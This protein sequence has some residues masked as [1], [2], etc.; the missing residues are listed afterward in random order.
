M[1]DKTVGEWESVSNAGEWETSPSETK[2]RRGTIKGSIRRMQEPGF[3][4]PASQPIPTGKELAKGY[5]DVAKATGA[6]IG[7]MGTGLGELVPGP[8]GEASAKGSKYL[9]GVITEAEKTPGVSPLSTALSL[10]APFGLGG[11]FISAAKTL[12][13]MAG[14]TSA[15]GAGYGAATPTGEEDYGERVIGKA[16]PTAL[17]VVTGALPLGVY[18]SKAASD[19]IRKASGKTYQ[20]AISDLKDIVTKEAKEAS[21]ILQKQYCHLN[22]QIHL[23]KCQ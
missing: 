15:V 7:E 21:D 19:L 4:P 8:I 14:R 16:V 5:T 17:G 11:K 1:T 6:K 20:Q 23:S 22:M 10:A 12:P 13:A 3:V 2:E 18:A 9:K